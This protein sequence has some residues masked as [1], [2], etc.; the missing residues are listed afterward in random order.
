MRPG[1]VH[2]ILKNIVADQRITIDEMSTPNRRYEDLI[3]REIG[4]HDTLVLG[5]REPP[6]A[7][8]GFPSA[9]ERIASHCDKPMVMVKSNSLFGRL[10]KRLF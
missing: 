2:N 7:R 4:N 3:C 6:A 10:A 9:T 5:L 8:L 1:H